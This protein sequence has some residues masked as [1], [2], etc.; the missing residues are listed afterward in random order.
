ITSLGAAIMPGAAITSLGVAITLGGAIT[1]PGVVA[2]SPPTP[3]AAVTGEAIGVV[4]IVAASL[5]RAWAWPS[6]ASGRAFMIT[7]GPT[8]PITT[9]PTDASSDSLFRAPSGGGG[10]WSTCANTSHLK[11][12]QP[13]AA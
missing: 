7:M 12:W 1:W 3:G 9:T 11:A 8:M 10:N 4:S 2:I 5:V 6:P 13:L